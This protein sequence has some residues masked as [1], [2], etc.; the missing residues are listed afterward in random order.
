LALH[1]KFKIL[2]CHISFFP[3]ILGVGHH[4]DKLPFFGDFYEIGRRSGGAIDRLGY[5]LFE[6]FEA[7]DSSTLVLDDFCNLFGW[8]EH[9]SLRDVVYKKFIPFQKQGFRLWAVADF[10]EFQQP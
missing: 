8:A 9:F 2:Y 10:E 7:F 6:I 5:Q 3:A 1:G 4:F